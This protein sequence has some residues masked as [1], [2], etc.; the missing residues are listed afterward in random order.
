MPLFKWIS[1]NVNYFVIDGL[2]RKLLF[3]E[4]RYN[5]KNLCLPTREKKKVEVNRLNRFIAK[6]N[7]FIIKEKGNIFLYF[8]FCSSKLKIY[9]CVRYQAKPP[10][11][12]FNSFTIWLTSV[13]D[14]YFKS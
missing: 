2:Y 8:L 5:F 12:T 11:K 10:R 6:L 14:S 1:I 13:W 4:K 3:K 9:Y 7:R